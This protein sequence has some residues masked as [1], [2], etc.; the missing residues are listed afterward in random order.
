MLS[1]QN[2]GDLMNAHQVT[3]GWFQGGFK[4][5][6]PATSTTKAV[7]ASTHR[8]AANATV[9]DYVQHH[10]PFQYY[11]STANVHHVPPS[12]PAMIG[13]SDDAKHQYDLSDFDTALAAGNLPSVSF[14]KAAA[15]EDGAPG[16]LGP[17]RRAA[18]HRPHAE[19]P[20]AVAR[21]GRAPRSSSPMTT[22]TAG[23]TM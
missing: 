19:R 10:E 13:S 4:P 3:W 7:C 21:C 22:P 2:I 23:T 20:R 16:E 17:A 8:N 12:S 1:G 5:T 6:T 9:R 11:Q 14:L 15:F 18:L